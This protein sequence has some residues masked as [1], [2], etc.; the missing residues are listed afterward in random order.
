MILPLLDYSDIAWGD[1]H[2]KTLMAKIQ[3]L[4]NKAAK[5]I[6]GKAKHSSTTEVTI[7]ELGWTVLSEMR[8]QHRL[9]FIFK[10]MH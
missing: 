8:R 1:K 3:F 6:L 2:N 4:L 10:C 7:S 5:I 9:S